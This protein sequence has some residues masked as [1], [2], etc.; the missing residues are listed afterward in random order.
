M[1]RFGRKL[2]RKDRLGRRLVRK[3]R[4]GRRLVRKDRLGRKLRLAVKVIYQRVLTN[5]FYYAFGF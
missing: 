2:V 1:I 5:N 4:L 3:D